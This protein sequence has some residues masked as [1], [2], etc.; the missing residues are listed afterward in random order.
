[1]LSRIDRLEAPIAEAILAVTPDPQGLRVCVVP[2]ETVAHAA[3]LLFGFGA[4][5]EVLEPPELRSEL[6]HRASRMQALYLED[7]SS[8]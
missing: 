8:I 6:L 3:D 1:V 2:I 7:A 5:I 4:D